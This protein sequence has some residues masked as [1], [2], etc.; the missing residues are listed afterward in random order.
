MM[1]RRDYF[2]AIKAEIAGKADAEYIE[3]ID[4]EIK[5]IDERNAKV[6]DKRAAKTADAA[7]AIQEAA[8]AALE[9]AGRAITLAEL[10][11]A[12][13]YPAGKVV[14]HIRPLVAAGAIIKEKAKVGDRKIMTYKV[15]E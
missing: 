7:A 15:A 13:G 12:V 8:I 3:F 2:V 10:V 6:K 9:D 5:R 11:A 4:A 14:Y 1:K